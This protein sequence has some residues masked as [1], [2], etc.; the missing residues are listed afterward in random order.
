MVSSICCDGPIRIGKINAVNKRCVGS[1]NLGRYLLK[2]DRASLPVI[3]Q[4]GRAKNLRKEGHYLF[5]GFALESKKLKKSNGCAL[6]AGVETF[7]DRIHVLIVICFFK[8][9]QN[10]FWLRFC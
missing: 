10:V 7:N 6:H 9:W 5:H 3:Q 2:P 4:A 1:V 8:L